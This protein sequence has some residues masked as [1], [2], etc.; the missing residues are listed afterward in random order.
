MTKQKR[1]WLF[2]GISQSSELG[3]LLTFSTRKVKESRPELEPDSIELRKAVV[4]KLNEI[5]GCKILPNDFI[6]LGPNYLYTE[7]GKE[8][9]NQIR[10]FIESLREKHQ[11]AVVR[12]VGV[13]SQR[14]DLG[15]SM[16]V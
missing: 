1:E 9:A 12:Q 11:M 6:A 5:T 13:S 2:D 4:V 3:Q 14:V 15:V 16:R 7:P 10:S 8:A